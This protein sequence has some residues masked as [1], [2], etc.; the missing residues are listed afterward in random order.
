MRSSFVGVS[1]LF[2]FCVYLFLTCCLV[3]YLNV[4]AQPFSFVGRHKGSIWHLVLN[5]FL[6]KRTKTLGNGYVS[7]VYHLL[8][9]LFMVAEP[10]L[11]PPSLALGAPLLLSSLLDKAPRQGDMQ[12]FTAVRR[13]AI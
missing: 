2:S 11:L 10:V 12:E 1:L 8:V 5:T 6:K 3:A 4:Y 13:L 7:H 9:F